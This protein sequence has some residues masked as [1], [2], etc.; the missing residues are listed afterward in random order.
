MSTNLREREVALQEFYHG[1]MDVSV[2]ERE[3]AQ[4]AA[5]IPLATVH[6][7][8]EKLL[9][10]ASDERFVMNYWLKVCK[11]RAQRGI[12]MPWDVVH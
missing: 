7:I 9:S 4:I 10:L 12:P 2:Q 11:V 8:R 3:I 6:S 1:V 5:L